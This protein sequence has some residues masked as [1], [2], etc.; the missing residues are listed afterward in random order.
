M[1]TTPM[2]TMNVSPQSTFSCPLCEDQ[3]WVY[4]PETNAYKRCS[5]YA[6]K[7][8]K[9]INEKSG[10]PPSE[11]ER[12]TLDNFNTNTEE[13]KKMLSL[14]ES[15][16]SNPRGGIGYFGKS[17]T[18]KTH[19][20]IAICQKLAEKGMNFQ[21]LSYRREMRNLIANIFDDAYVNQ[22]MNDWSKVDVLYID[23]LLKLSADKDG[24]PNNRELQIL[25]EL[26]NNR[27]LNGNLT[28]FSSEYSLN[29]IAKIDE[30]TGSRIYSMI[31][32]HAMACKGENHR[33][34]R[35]K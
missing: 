16:L 33:I 13:Q 10:F 5:C 35:S 15:F 24:K 31:Y 12:M 2:E 8:M 23:D 28:I 27:M 4:V 6:I 14:A 32:P 22:K 18:G 11:F 19:I 7:R 34:G 3:G 20:C 30:A 26:I 21:Y 9:R 29:E 17:G 1:N 25:Y